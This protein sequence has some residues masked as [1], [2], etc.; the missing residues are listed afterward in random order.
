[1]EVARSIDRALVKLTFAQS[2]NYTATESLFKVSI[3][4]LDRA[5][6]ESNEGEYENKR[7]QQKLSVSSM[8]IVFIKST[9]GLAIF[10]YHEVYQ[11]SGVYAGLIISAIYIFTVVHGSM[12]MVTFADEIENSEKY[13]NYRVDTY[14][15][16]V[17]LMLGE[18]YPKAARILGPVTFFL[19]FFSTV[20]YA[21]S[22]ALALT[23]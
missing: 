19:C 23:E 11:K 20:G 18:K 3:R 8:F 22:T 13:K 6:L 2:I 7:N 16:L 10:G 4:M 12:R 1:M 14:F 15:E 5:V 17:E 21:L 9:I